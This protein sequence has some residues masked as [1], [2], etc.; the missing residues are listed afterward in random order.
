MPNDYSP[1][2][3]AT[4]LDRY[5]SARTA[6]EIAWLVRQLPLPAYRRVLDVACGSGRHALP[7]AALGYHVTGVDRDSSAIATAQHHAPDGAVFCVGD[8]R[9]L[10][11][12]P[13]PFD[14]VLSLWQ[15]FGYFDSATNAA[16]LGQMAAC[17]CPGG[18]LI[19]DLNHRDFFAAHQG[20]RIIERADRTIRETGHLDGDRYTVTLDYGPAQ[21]PDRFD[22]QIY[23][24][25]EIVAL[26]APLGLRPVLLCSEFDAAQPAGPDHAR[27]QVVLAK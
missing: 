10:R 1:H 9:D 6:A 8:M 15:S 20:E 27:M 17:L 14:A 26:A 5:D 4:F 24:P 3:F 16:V 19:L 7:L 12:V 18:R 2:W 11:A 25:A 23:T 13:G 22:W 21:P